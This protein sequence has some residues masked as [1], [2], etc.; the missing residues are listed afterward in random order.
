LA[1]TLLVSEPP[2]SRII[3]DSL[4]EADHFF[5][6]ANDVPHDEEVP[7]EAEPRDQIEFVIDL[8]LRPLQ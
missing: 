6:E 3:A 7:C 5:A 1:S 8:L 2:G 4:T